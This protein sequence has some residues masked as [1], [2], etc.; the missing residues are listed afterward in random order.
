MLVRPHAP[1]AQPTRRL[2]GSGSHG[3]IAV[4]ASSVNQPRPT[5]R[6]W[7]TRRHGEPF[8][9]R[10]ADEYAADNAT[11]DPRGRRHRSVY[12]AA[13]SSAIPLSGGRSSTIV[14]VSPSRWL[15]E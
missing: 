11:G 2:A 14:C 10:I 1:P 15:Y 13:G 9:A 7:M 4:H 12:T 6:A 3:S 8:A 5:T